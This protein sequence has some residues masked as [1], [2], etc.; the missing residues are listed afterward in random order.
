MMIRVRSALSTRAAALVFFIGV[1]LIGLGYFIEASETSTINPIM[2]W[3]RAYLYILVGG[4]LIGI[5]TW[6]NF[7]P[8]RFSTQQYTYN[9]MDHEDTSVYKRDDLNDMY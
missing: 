1:Y 8:K 7:K 9:P 3:N 4:I 6:V 2:N 5:Y